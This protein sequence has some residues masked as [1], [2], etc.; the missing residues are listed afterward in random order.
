MGSKGR[1]KPHHPEFYPVGWVS[2]AKNSAETLKEGAKQSDWVSADWSRGEAG[3]VQ[4]MKRMRAFRDGLTANRYNYAKIAQLIDE[5][6]ALTFR[7]VAA[8]NVW[9]IQ[10]CW[11]KAADKQ[12][13]LDITRE[14]IGEDMPE[15]Y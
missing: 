8:H 5:G 1:Y 9:D 12:E 14:A 3:A 7:K 15:K 2:A 11:K 6:F 4:R 13:L 10:L